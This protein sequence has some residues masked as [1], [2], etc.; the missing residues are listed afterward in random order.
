MKYSDDTHEV[1]SVPD[2]E[3][4]NL[5]GGAALQRYWSITIRPTTRVSDIPKRWQSAFRNLRLESELARHIPESNGVIPSSF[6]RKTKQGEEY[7][8]RRRV[9][10]PS[11]LDSDKGL[12]VL[13]PYFRRE[14]LNKAEVIM[15]VCPTC[16]SRNGDT[17]DDEIHTIRI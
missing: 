4:L 3:K 5:G 7:N 12:M 11:H 15:H 14:R 9:N 1:E 13:S 16:P 6:A 2:G 17:P 10:P 8:G